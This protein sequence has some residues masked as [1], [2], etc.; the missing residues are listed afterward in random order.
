MQSTAAIYRQ[1]SAR[2]LEDA[3]AGT[4]PKHAGDLYLPF[5]LVEQSWP[6]VLV[7]SLFNLRLHDVYSCTSVS[8]T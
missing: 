5:D 6:L 8:L 4:L 2:L 7:G 3:K 1:V